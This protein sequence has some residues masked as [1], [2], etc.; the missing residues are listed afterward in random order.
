MPLIFNFLE[1]G[2]PLDCKY[3]CQPAFLTESL[4][5]EGKEKEEDED[6]FSET[7]EADSG[8][9]SY[10]DNNIISLHILKAWRV[11]N[12]KFDSEF[13]IADWACGIDPQ[14]REDVKKRLNGELRTKTESVAKKLFSDQINMDMTKITD[15][16]WY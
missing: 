1:R 11:R 2:C 5:E 14:I 15:K 9:E 8:D 6:E 3:T 12:N 7:E 16:F 4:D 13:S 10:E